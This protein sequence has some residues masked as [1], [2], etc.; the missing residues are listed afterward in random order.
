MKDA[1]AKPA[2]KNYKPDKCIVWEEDGEGIIPR[3]I[4]DGCK[5]G[6]ASDPLHR[7]RDMRHKNRLKF[8]GQLNIWI[9]A[10]G[11]WTVSTMQEG[12]PD[13]DAESLRKRGLWQMP[14]NEW[15][16]EWKAS[17]REGMPHPIYEAAKAVRCGIATI[18][19]RI[20][21]IKATMN[22]VASLDAKPLRLIQSAI[23]ALKNCNRDSSGIRAAGTLTDVERA[24][25]AIALLTAKLKRVPFVSEVRA[26]MSKG[27]REPMDAARMSRVLDKAGFAWLPDNT[28]A[29]GARA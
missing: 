3:K 11:A 20:T 1:R 26:M 22:A 15:P 6:V 25:H 16:E 17:H 7:G 18:D 10:A 28:K 8:A 12:V 9:S 13:S 4:P 24:T 5:S 19:D 23:Q 2:K 27:R 29:K 14:P 21:L